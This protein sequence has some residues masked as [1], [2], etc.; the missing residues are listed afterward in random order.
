MFGLNLSLLFM[1]HLARGDGEPTWSFSALTRGRKTCVRGV[2]F[3]LSKNGLK[4]SDEK[5]GMLISVG[6][7]LFTFNFFVVVVGETIFFLEVLDLSEQSQDKILSTQTKRT[8][9][10]F[11]V[12][13]FV[14]NQLE[15]NMLRAKSFSR[16]L[17]L[18]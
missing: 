10:I 18:L 17:Q 1:Q 15:K 8:K 5:P 14:D 9:E 12:W 6:E 2:L 4:F 16:C 7:A 13:D 3:W 11:R